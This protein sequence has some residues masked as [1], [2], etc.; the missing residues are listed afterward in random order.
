M[1]LFGADAAACDCGAAAVVF[2]PVATKSRR[3]NCATPGHQPGRYC[4]YFPGPLP[5][6]CEPRRFSTSFHR[7]ATYAAGTELAKTLHTY[8]E[9]G[10]MDF[11]RRKREK[12]LQ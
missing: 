6:G 9:N 8:R 5:A 10:K 2:F 7:G 11:I 1:V 4:R 3:Q 12:I